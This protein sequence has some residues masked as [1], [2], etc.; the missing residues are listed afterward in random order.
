MSGDGK[1][2]DR[3]KFVTVATIAISLLSA[4]VAMRSCDISRRTNERL[5]YDATTNFN[6]IQNL[7]TSE[8]NFTLYNESTKKLDQPPSPTY[9]MAIPSKVHW[10]M[11][12]GSMSNLVL[13]PV[14]YDVILEQVKTGETTGVVE[15][16]MLP[17]S[18][19]AKEG[20][21][22]LVI[23]KKIELA[24]RVAVKVETLPF[25][26]IV[27]NISYSLV[28]GGGVKTSR[29]VT[30]PLGRDEWSESDVD[31]LVTYFQD[32]ADFEVVPPPEGDKKTVY[33]VAHEAVVDEVR[34]MG[35]DN[36]SLFGGTEDGYGLVLKKL[37]SMITPRDPLEA[38]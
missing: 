32:N 38:D 10:L 19:F 15:K 5:E 18:F 11:D 8:P 6:I 7:W 13:L 14:S 28:G 20:G 22:D 21:R 23:S 9:L 17:A 4:A 12:K 3:R 27:A 33:D 16:S 29:I 1:E 34:N 25:V 37:N 2:F 24:D 30:T 36:A 31:H 35:A 26:L